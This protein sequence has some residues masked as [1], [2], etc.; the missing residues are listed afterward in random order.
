MR[1]INNN[2]KNSTIRKIYL[3]KI[4]TFLNLIIDNKTIEAAETKNKYNSTCNHTAIF[5]KCRI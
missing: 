4:S 2:I 1:E 3:N 5:Q